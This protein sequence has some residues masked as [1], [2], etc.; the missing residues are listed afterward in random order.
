ML[1]SGEILMTGKSFQGGL[2]QQGIKQMRKPTKL[3]L[4]SKLYKKVAQQLATL[5]KIKVGFVDANVL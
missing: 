2:L 5:L 1:S 4:G 3:H